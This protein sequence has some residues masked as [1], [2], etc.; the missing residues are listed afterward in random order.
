MLYYPPLFT[1]THVPLPTWSLSRKS[2]S[3]SAQRASS[4]GPADSSVPSVFA[5]PLV[6]LE[7]SPERFPQS[8]PALP[9]TVGNSDRP[10]EIVYPQ[11][12]SG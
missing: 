4:A 12:L 6:F 2:L 11:V 1:K 10:E 5:S 3:C 9:A 8:Q 7:R